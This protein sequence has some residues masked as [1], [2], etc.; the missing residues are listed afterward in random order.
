MKK[1]AYEDPEL[2]KPPQSVLPQ[3][4]I[5]R[6]LQ[7]FME[8]MEKRQVEVLSKAADSLDEAINNANEQLN[9]ERIQETVA[10]AIADGIRVEHK[11]VNKN[12]VSKVEIP[13][14]LTE[15]LLQL[16]S[17]VATLQ[18]ASTSLDDFRPHDQ[19]QA[20]EQ[21]YYGFM[22]PDGRW[23]IMRN[24]DNTQRYASGV[25]KYTTAWANRKQLTYTTIDAVFS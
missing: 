25:G 20:G 17:A 4:V 23:L 24:V 6:A 8:D 22:H 1:T 3:G 10:K 9:V 11:T 2:A 12:I 21:E 13:S 15:A 14:E 5:R 16:V 7:P 18:V 19:S